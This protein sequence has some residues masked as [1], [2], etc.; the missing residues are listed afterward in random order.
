MG[1]NKMKFEPMSDEEYQS[2][3]NAPFSIFSY[4][5]FR[6]LAF[7]WRLFK[8]RFKRTAHASSGFQYYPRHDKTL[9]VTVVRVT[10]Y[11]VEFKTENCDSIRTRSR[12]GF[13]KSYLPIKK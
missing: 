11:S 5:T 12:K 8:N 2:L 4:F 13:E 1:N 6:E 3:L 10:D 7:R 9:S